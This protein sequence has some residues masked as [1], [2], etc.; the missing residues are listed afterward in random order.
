MVPVIKRFNR[1]GAGLRMATNPT[2]PVLALTPALVEGQLW[3]FANLPPVRS[4]PV[5]VAGLAAVAG[6]RVSGRFALL[7]V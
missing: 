5:M 6:G 3:K 7:P 4:N 2:R 1:S